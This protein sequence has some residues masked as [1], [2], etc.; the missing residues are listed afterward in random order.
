M[1][2]QLSHAERTGWAE[3]QFGEAVLGDVRRTRR[4]VK[5]GAQM[6][7]NSSGSIPQQ[8]ECVADMKA[9]YRLFAQAEV[10]HEAICRP[11]VEQTR[12]RAND[13]PVVY[14]LQDTAELDYTRHAKTEGLGPVGTGRCQGLH[15]HNVLAADP[16]TRRPLGL[17]YQ[18]HH[19]RKERPPGETREERRRRPLSDRESYWWIEAIRAVGQ[20]TEDVG[21]VHVLDRGGDTFAVHD[22]IR[23]LG[24]DCLIRA[25]TDRRIEPNDGHRHLFAYARSLSSLG[26][27]EIPVRCPTGSTRQATLAVTGGAVTFLPSAM[28]PE[29]RHREPMPRQVV[30]VWEPD[31]PTDEGPVEW[32]L[33]TTLPAG[34]YEEVKGVVDGYSLRWLI[35]EFHKCE[36]TG[37]RVEDRQLTHT[38]RLEPLIGLLSVLA[39]H[40]LDLKYVARDSP[41]TPAREV[42]GRDAVQV[43]ACYL[44]KPGSDL[45]VEAFWRGVGQLG[46]HPGRKG[47]GP[48]GWLRA[49]RGWQAFQLILL[50]AELSATTG[51]ARCG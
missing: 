48:L 22:L 49:W 45:T 14:M 35:E 39:V 21:W 34:T 15:Q 19:L 1:D 40:L 25:R 13:L 9:A 6:A 4:L 37:C 36:K 28:E 5:L 7:G 2:G 41:K 50:G 26:S 47:D 16:Q 3:A 27:F 17:M 24:V 44:R 38:D 11:H 43:M 23:E 29:L 8:T 30:R 31:P 12:A 42:F 46:G 18:Q 33:L 32:I 51:T 20:P 10:T